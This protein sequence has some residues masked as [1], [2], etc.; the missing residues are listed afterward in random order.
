MSIH[1]TA[2]VSPDAAIED[3]ASIGPYCIIDGNV[4]I[5]AGT[6][7]HAHVC[8]RSGTTI[9][10]DNEIFSFASIGEIPQDLKFKRD[11]D[12]RLIIGDNNTIREFVTMNRGTT[13]GGG[14]TSVGNRNLFMAYSHLAHDCVVGSGNVFANNAI[15]A[16]H[17]TVQ[18]NAILGGM[19]AVHQFC[20]IGEGAMLGGGSIVVQDITPFVIAQGNHAR[21]IT[22]NKI[23]MQR[24]GFSA[25][26]ISAT[27]KA[28]RILFRTT[29]T[30][31]SREAAL[32][33]LAVSAPPVAKM[34]QFYRNSQRGLAHCRNR[35]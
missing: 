21:V 14:V 34:L 26:E 23:G 28:F 11:E 16:G 9:G 12:T 1:P 8:V 10:R 18:D 6:V 27:K 2:L 22:I 30:K 3:G 33:E 35:Q 20:T 24:R 5:G 13:H 15:L 31:E 17:V 25:D 4:T 32:E 7:I 29:M 19:S